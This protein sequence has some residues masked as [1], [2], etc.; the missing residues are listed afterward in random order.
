MKNIAL[1]FL[2][3]GCVICSFGQTDTRFWFAVP[4]VTSQH[5]D[6]P[7]NLHV[8]AG[9]SD[10]EVTIS[11]PADSSIAPLVFRLKA[12]ETRSIDL[13]EEF[14]S[15]ELLE[16]DSPNTIENKGLLIESDQLVSVYYEVL[17]TSEYGYGIVNTDIFTLKG[18]NGLGKE[19]YTPFQTTFDNYRFGS[20]PDAWSSID[21]V[22]SEDNTRINITPTSA[23]F[24]I[25]EDIP[26]NT[27]I[28][29]TL[30]KGETY[31][32][33]NAS[34]LA[35]NSLSGSHVVAD[36]PIAVTVKDD[37]VLDRSGTSYDLVGDQLVP[38]RMLGTKYFTGGG[39]LYLVSIEDNTDVTVSYL[40]TLG[41]V[42]E[43]D[44]VLEKGQTLA[45]VDLVDKPIDNY[46]EINS[47][48]P[49]YVFGVKQLGR[50]YGGAMIPKVRCT[51]SRRVS[52]A[53]TTIETLT[54]EIVTK[55]ENKD[56][57][58]LNGI[59]FDFGKAESINGW[60]YGYVLLDPNDYPINEPLVVEN[61]SG[62]F[63]LGVIS[64][65]SVTGVRFGYFSD[66]GTLE[67]GG[68]QTLCKGETTTLDA[69]SGRDSYSWSQ[70]DNSEFSSDNQ[71][72]EVNETGEYIVE[73]KEG[74]CEAIDTITV[75]VNPKLTPI[76]LG[77]ETKFCE[78][79]S[80]ILKGP[81]D[82]TS[83]LWQDGSIKESFTINETGEYS[84]VASNEFA[85]SD[86]ASLSVT[87]FAYP[88]VE[89]AS[90]VSICEST[91][92]SVVLNEGYARY[93]WYLGD[94]LI[95]EV[96]SSYVFKEEGDYSVAVSNFCGTDSSAIK[97]EFWHVEIPNVI[98]PND[99]GKN[100]Q[101]VISGIEQG[102]WD[103]TVYN[104]WGKSVYHNSN[105]KNN[106]IST[107]ED[108]TFYYYLK[109]E[110]ECNEFKGWL[111][112]IGGN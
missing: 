68:S 37:S 75:T 107:E 102:A 31:S 76:D 73:I 38:V 61:S 101:F 48:I 57:F 8:S 83:F 110:D 22:A 41:N 43:I 58:T 24:S 81:S 46:F 63:H 97:L 78:N 85:C 104:R 98:T 19:F 96:V 42:S 5:A 27:S 26:A 52:V 91:T 20:D 17:G 45:I 55:T 77:S 54:F 53:N 103:L 10:T 64:G 49:T 93:N 67:L 3:V 92:Y 47:S 111:Y 59:A 44:T 23:V 15:L 80:I 33:R 7:V 62:V 112:I 70:I 88:R 108:G 100:D 82:A 86:S 6:K 35:E 89:T 21:I 69:G 36:K 16:N 95:G 74:E 25:P 9:G 94:V 1:Y 12:L 32:I 2:F 28:I 109:N 106:W 40:N 56:H 50:E 30:D 14:A 60:Y 66:F 90:E 11:V 87:K 99:D 105:F 79:D 51:G 65:G 29:I 13:I 39:Y 84:L 18:S 71:T 4:E 72:I 34:Q